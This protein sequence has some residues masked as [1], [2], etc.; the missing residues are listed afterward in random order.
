MERLSVTKAHG[1]GND[2]VVIGDPDD[3]ID[4]DPE[5]VRALCS[6]HFG[7]GAD[8]LIR[9]T[10][11][12]SGNWFM[13]YRNSD[14]SVAEMCGNGIRCMT[15]YL[16]DRGWTSSSDPISG[17]SLTIET[18]AGPRS[19]TYTLG[20]DEKVESVEVDM[21]EPHFERDL[22]PMIGDT[23][24]V[25]GIRLDVAPV[26]TSLTVSA[27]SMGNPH[28]VIFV[29]D[30]ETVDVSKLGPAVERHPYFPEGSNVEFVSV[31]ATDRIEMRVWER[32]VGETLS[33]GT[34]ACA[35]F[36]VSRQLGYVDEEAV[37]SLPGGNLHIRWD[38][39]SI[40]MAG[41]A[42]EVFD[43]EVNLEELLSGVKRK[44][45]TTGAR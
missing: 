29:D 15:K 2:F 9:I 27:V 39:Q 26:G 22:I 24:T 40:K 4:V 45:D 33:C 19:V 41:P 34:G 36:A 30:L 28:A 38:H 43:A 10:R 1:T 8:G 13:D 20:P 12:K 35:A 44:L 31:L 18:R 3:T 16:V 11:G 6:R 37:T 7:V 5:L 32:G 14:G 25:L 21:G 23:Q 42:V 17:N